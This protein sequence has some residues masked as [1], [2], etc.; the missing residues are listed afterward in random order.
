[1]H[2]RSLPLTSSFQDR[3]YNDKLH[4]H[5]D[6]ERREVVEHYVAGLHWVLEY[7]YR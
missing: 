5:S 4:A 6:E 7:Y 1:V 3:Y 2:V